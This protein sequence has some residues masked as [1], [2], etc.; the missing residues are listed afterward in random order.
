[1]ALHPKAKDEEEVQISTTVMVKNIAL[2]TVVKLPKKVIDNC[3]IMA[4][5]EDIKQ[6]QT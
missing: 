4:K 2:L 3:T 1:M 6:R 5:E